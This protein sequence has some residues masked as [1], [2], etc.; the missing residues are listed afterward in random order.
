MDG[1]MKVE[2][3]KNDVFELLH[4]KKIISCYDVMEF[5]HSKHG[6]AAP[7]VQI[8]EVLTL[9]VKGKE[10]AGIYYGRHLGYR[11]SRGPVGV[12]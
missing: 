1:G 4:Q 5:T 9:L 3:L 8:Y 7:L 10:V 2:S 6:H 11:Y 12:S